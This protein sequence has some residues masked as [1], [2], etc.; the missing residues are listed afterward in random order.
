LSWLRPPPRLL[1]RRLV[2][3]QAVSAGTVY[4][5]HF[6]RPYKHAAHYIGWT[7][8][9]LE[10]RLRAHQSGTGARLLEVVTNAGITFELARTWEGSRRVERVKKRQGG[11]GRCCPICRA[12]GERR[13]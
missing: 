1:L 4:L 2:A 9:E 5:L 7:A 11:A 8:G 12:A 10:E 13:R 3:G 6:E